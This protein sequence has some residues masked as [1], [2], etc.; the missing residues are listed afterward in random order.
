LTVKTMGMG[1]CSFWHKPDKQAD[2]V[3]LTLC[4]G[5]LATRCIVCPRT[6]TTLGTSAPK[7]DVFQQTPS[8]FAPEPLRH[9]LFGAPASSYTSTTTGTSADAGASK[10]AVIDYSG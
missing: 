9:I 10:Q 8:D 2:D 3:N 4:P 5:L 6:Q 1:L 7:A